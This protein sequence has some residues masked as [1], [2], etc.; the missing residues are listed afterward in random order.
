MARLAGTS[1]VVRADDR[2]GADLGA[3]ARRARAQRR[4]GVGGRQA[5]SGEWERDRG[6]RQS[7]GRRRRRA[8]RQ[9]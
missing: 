9:R 2:R 5:R 7:Q 8:T 6:V 1:H 4:G 3:R